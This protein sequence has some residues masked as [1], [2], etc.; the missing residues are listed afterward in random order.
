MIKA[1]PAQPVHG[2]AP[3]TY[4]IRTVFEHDPCLPVLSAPSP[5]FQL[6][7]AMDGDAP[8]RKIRIALP[9]ISNLRQFKRG[10]AIEMP[11]SLRRTARPGDPGDAAGQ[12]P[13]QR[14]RASSSG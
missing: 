3:D 13:R 10:V 12:G 6:A 8:A 5:P 14:P 2:Y 4:I 9:D 7:R 11:P 1:D